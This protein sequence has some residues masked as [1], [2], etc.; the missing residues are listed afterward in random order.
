M[1]EEVH[2]SHNADLPGDTIWS[3]LQLVG[4]FE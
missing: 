4:G 3:G 2:E 1:E